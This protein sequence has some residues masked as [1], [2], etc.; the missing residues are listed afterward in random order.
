MFERMFGAPS[1]PVSG[2]STLPIDVIERDGNLLVKAAVPGVDPANLDVTVENNV[3]TI[4]GE[5]NHESSNEGDKIY[6]REV[7]YG[8]FSRS[9]R[10]PE[11]LDLNAISASFE[12][13][14]VTVTLPR[15]PEV[16]PKA[17]KIEVKPT[18]NPQPALDTP[19][20]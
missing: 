5:T 10:L 9:I 8:A 11:N 13:G 17:L 20:E 1:R 18:A 15:V 14:T 4:R 3:L 2:A 6:R 19:T 7:S 12:H 16:K